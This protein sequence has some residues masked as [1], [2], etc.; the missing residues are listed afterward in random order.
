MKTHDN[1]KNGFNF[2]ETYCVLYK[3]EVDAPL[4]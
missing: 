4:Y 1:G 3:L 2:Q